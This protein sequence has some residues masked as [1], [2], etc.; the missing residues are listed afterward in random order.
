MQNN[1]DQAMASLK[2]LAHQFRR[3]IP[4]SDVYQIKFGDRSSVSR[5]LDVC[6]KKFKPLSKQS[7]RLKALCKSYKSFLG[8]CKQ[9][10][11]I[12]FQMIENEFFNNCDRVKQ[13]LGVSHRSTR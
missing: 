9:A 4:K 11:V 13:N 6:T 7:I 3:G 10:T 5:E 1:D 8:T 2:A 12:L